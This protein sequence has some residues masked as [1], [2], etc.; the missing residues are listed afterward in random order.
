MNGF[1]NGGFPNVK[2]SWAAS[3]PSG[4]C[5]SPEEIFPD[6]WRTLD[7]PVRQARSFT[8]Q[9]SPGDDDP[10]G[11]RVQAFDCL[12][13]RPISGYQHTP[14]MGRRIRSSLRSPQVGL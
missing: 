8:D 3:S 10:Y 1:D 12:Q 6:G 7:F 13:N 9:V 14:F 11:W 4:A 5:Y 2:V